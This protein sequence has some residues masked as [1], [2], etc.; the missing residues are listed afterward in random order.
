[1][2]EPTQHQSYDPYGDTAPHTALPPTPTKHN[3]LKIL[4]IAVG[5]LLLV[6]AIGTV[7]LVS[8]YAGKVSNKPTPISHP[9]VVKSHLTPRPTIIVETPTP[10]PQ[11]ATVTTASALYQDFVN[12][13]L[14]PGQPT[15]DNNWSDY[16]TY[17]PLGGALYW[18]D[19]GRCD[20]PCNVIEIAVF[21]T[22]QHAEQDRQEFTK[23]GWAT[24]YVND[25]VL[26]WNWLEGTP[27]DLPAYIHVMSGVC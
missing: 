12:A 23:Q 22:Q 10:V 7:G 21:Q 3:W 6:G 14:R 27:D 9:A 25:C 15:V 8:Y 2:Q 19:L 11:P 18:N 13:G 24:S 5:A 20:G 4:G 1:M 26:M 17:Y 16:Y